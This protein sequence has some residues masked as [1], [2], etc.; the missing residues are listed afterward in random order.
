MSPALRLRSIELLIALLIA[1][2][3][4]GA[5]GG[6]SSGQDGNGPS[7]IGPSVAEPT[8][9]GTFE[10]SFGF[11]DFGMEVQGAL[12]QRDLTFFVDNV[13]LE[14][15]SCGIDLPSPPE[16]CAGAPADASRPAV[17]LSVWEAE[18]RYLDSAQYRE[19][20][21]AFLNEYAQGERDAYGDAAS[22]LYAYAIV[23]P[24]LQSFRSD[25]ES[26]EAIITRIVRTGS[27]AEREALLLTSTFDGERWT[28][29]R[30]TMGPATFLEPTGPK[31]SPAE[32]GGVF[33]FWRLWED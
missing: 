28:V 13:A 18:D 25:D 24:E 10:D 17:L 15:V 11:H 6:G 4:A 30:L 12:Q 26:V 20:M 31:G 21:E 1:V 3:A 5:C 9:I 19:F 27:G 7:G 32:P 22:R 16:S 23:D 8:Q 2:T 33:E 29:S 14:E